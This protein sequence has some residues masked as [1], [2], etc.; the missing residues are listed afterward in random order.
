MTLNSH[1]NSARGQRQRQVGRRIFV[2]CLALKLFRRGSVGNEYDSREATGCELQLPHF[3]RQPTD[4]SDG[5]RGYTV[6]CCNSATHGRRA[7]AHVMSCHVMS[8]HQGSNQSAHLPKQKH[9]TYAAT[10]RSL[11]VIL[12]LLKLRARAP[13]AP[14]APS[15]LNHLSSAAEAASASV[16]SLATI[17][18]TC[19]R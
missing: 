5:R 7:G 14:P 18:C 9:S 2:M 4:A 17:A 6:E 13:A 1:L 10:D 8:C 19:R 12:T 11:S 3:C 16:S 15:L